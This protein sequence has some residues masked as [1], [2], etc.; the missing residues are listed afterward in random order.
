MI[1]ELVEG[2]SSM[3]QNVEWF[4]VNE[5]ALVRNLR[6]CQQA[7]HNRL[8]CKISRFSPNEGNTLL[9]TILFHTDC[10]SSFGSGGMWES[11]GKN[12]GP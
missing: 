5:L 2:E 7:S 1:S 3:P 12:Y 11:C 10:D 8:E 6:N 9:K 4:E